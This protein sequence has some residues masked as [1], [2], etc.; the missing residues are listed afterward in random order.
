MHLWQTHHHFPCTSCARNFE[1]F[2]NLITN[3][4]A[5]EGKSEKKY[6]LSE[7][8]SPKLLLTTNLTISNSDRS[9]RRRQFFVPIGAFYGSL[10]DR[11]GYAPRDVHE[12]YLLD[13]R[14]WS[15]DDW[16]DFY[17][18]CIH[19]LHESLTHGLLPFDDT[20]LAGRQLLKT[21]G[22]LE[23]LLTDLTMFINEVLQ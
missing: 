17:A 5:V 16:S 20:A 4:F 6:V 8:C 23:D 9:G 2:F 19:C 21:V 10:C 11:S 12:G 18:T 22:G 15:D 14:T 7:E 3:G 1:R 13:K